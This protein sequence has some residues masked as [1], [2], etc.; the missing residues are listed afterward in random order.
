MDQF[1]K[2]R[3]DRSMWNGIGFVDV[4]TAAEPTWAAAAVV[5]S[6]VTQDERHAD[7]NQLIRQVMQLQ[8]CL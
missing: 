2:N 8:V 4:E 7:R 3:E 6:S 5:S 1:N